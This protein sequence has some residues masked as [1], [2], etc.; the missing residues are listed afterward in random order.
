MARSAR[1]DT[2]AE[3]ADVQ[4]SVV[5]WLDQVTRAQSPEEMLHAARAA[6]KSARSVKRFLDAEANHRAVK[7]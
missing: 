7:A 4:D 5:D 2:A 3:A 1:P 6:L